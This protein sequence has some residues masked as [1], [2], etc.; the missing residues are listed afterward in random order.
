[1][2]RF[3]MTVAVVGMVMLFASI[4]FG[5]YAWAPYAAWG[6]AA[7]SSSS[8]GYD[9]PPARA[10]SSSGYWGNLAATYRAWGNAASSSGWNAGSSSSGVNQYNYVGLASSGYGYRNYASSSGGYVPASG[11]SSGWYGYYR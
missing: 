8:S 9:W 7:S 3:A 2:K 4:S 11:S 10:A 5:F 6:N 1:M